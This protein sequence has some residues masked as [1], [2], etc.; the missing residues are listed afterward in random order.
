ML[1]NV[2]IL[3]FK[4]LSAAFWTFAKR[5]FAC[6][7]D[8]GDW[9]LGLSFFFGLWLAPFKFEA[10]IFL[11]GLHQECFERSAFARNEAREQIGLAGTEQFFHLL[12]IYRLLQNDF[13]GS[14]VARLIGANCIFA[15]VDPSQLHNGPAT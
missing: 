3:S 9:F 8:F 7:I 13:A 4:N 15:K 2:A 12:G 14:K 11:V 6:E 1:T 10:D 5:F